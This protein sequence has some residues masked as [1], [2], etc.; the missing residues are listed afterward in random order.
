MTI[1]T[2]FP[3][4]LLLTSSTQDYWPH[5]TSGIGWV[6]TG[7]FMVVGSMYCIHRVLVIL[8]IVSHSLGNDCLKDLQARILLK[9]FAS[10][11]EG[12][13]APFVLKTACLTIS[14]L[15]SVYTDFGN[16]SSIGP[17]EYEFLKQWIHALVGKLNNRCFCGFPAAI[18]VPLKGTPTWR[19]HTKLINLG[20]TFFPNISHMKYRTDLILGEAFCIIFLIFFHFPNSGYSVLNGLHFYFWRRSNENR[21][22]FNTCSSAV[23]LFRL[24]CPHPHPEKKKS[25]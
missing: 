12:P 13:P 19:R 9:P 7:G 18:F 24:G 15:I 20:K 10:T 4:T 23:T 17:N 6:T 5:S 16:S 22:W 11:P 3:H 8:A 14:Q 25:E 21:E 2:H 1:I